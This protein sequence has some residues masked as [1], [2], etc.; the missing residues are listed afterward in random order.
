[1]PYRMILVGKPTDDSGF[2]GAA[3]AS[4]DL[5]GEEEANR[6]AVQVPDPF[7]KRVLTVANRKVLEL[8]E[9]RGVRI[10]FKDLGAGGIACVTSEMADAG[11]FG[12]TIDLG[13]VNLA[14]GHY[15]PAVVS[16]SETQERYCLAV[17]AD[18]VDD[19][20]RIYNEEFELPHLYHGA[21]AVVIGQVTG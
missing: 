20:L 17:P 15:P 12:V 3:F 7:L 6:G 8:A 14:V 21:G 16:C 5:A 13:N 11:G 9:R 19:V 4:E 2:G 1:M 10:G 18:I